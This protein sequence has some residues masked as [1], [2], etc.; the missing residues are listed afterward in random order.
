MCSGE[1]LLLLVPQVVSGLFC[2]P[3]TGYAQSGL[4]QALSKTGADRVAA[5]Q[6]GSKSLDRISEVF[7]EFCFGHTQG[8]QHVFA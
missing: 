1:T 4:L 3:D 6:C 2:Q 7:S 5:V 8:R